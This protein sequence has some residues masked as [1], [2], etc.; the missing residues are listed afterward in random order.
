MKPIL[1][2]EPVLQKP[3][4]GSQPYRITY[5]DGSTEV[6]VSN[7]GSAGSLVPYQPAPETISVDEAR[8][9][10]LGK[11][12]IKA[13]KRYRAGKDSGY[14]DQEYDAMVRSLTI[15]CPDWEDLL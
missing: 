10:P 7:S 6:K 2:I 3:C 14:T 8:K 15:Y 12:I 4:F 11:R 1:K 5:R 9:S 13:N